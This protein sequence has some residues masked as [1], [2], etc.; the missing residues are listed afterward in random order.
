[1]R[2]GCD[3]IIISKS[4]SADYYSQVPLSVQAKVKKLHEVENYK[5]LRNLFPF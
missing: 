1:V 3:T 2:G 4:N 5:D